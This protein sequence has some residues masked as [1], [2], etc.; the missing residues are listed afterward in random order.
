M[1]QITLTQSCSFIPTLV[2]KADIIFHLLLSSS[3]SFQFCCY[4]N[5]TLLWKPAIELLFNRKTGTCCHFW[6]V[7]RGS[8]WGVFTYWCQLK[9]IADDLMTCWPVDLCPLYFTGLVGGK[10]GPVV[11]NCGSSPL[12]NSKV[13]KGGFH[14]WCVCTRCWRATT[15]SPVSGVSFILWC[16]AGTHFTICFHSEMKLKGAK[17]KK[18]WKSEVGLTL[19]EPH[20]CQT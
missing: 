1:T 13:R 7:E 20:L 4:D 10:G 6:S 9:Q 8:L 2:F 16:A 14:I 18:R 15:A 5:T 11:I 19:S 3:L 12:C 17:W